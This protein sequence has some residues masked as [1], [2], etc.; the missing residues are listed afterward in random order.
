MPDGDLPSRTCGDLLRRFRE[1]ARARPDELQHR[2]PTSRRRAGVLQEELAGRTGLSDRGI[3]KIE[4]GESVPDP[5]TIA[6]LADALGLSPEQRALFQATANR[7]RAERRVQQNTRRL[8]PSPVTGSAF[9]VTGSASRLPLPPLIGRTRE[10][11]A[12]DHHI[13]GDGPPVLVF[14][15]E[16]GIGKSRLLD[17]AAAPCRTRRCWTR[18]SNTSM[19]NQWMTCGRNSAAA[20]GW[21]ACCLSSAP[22]VA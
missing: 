16:P 17:E 7:E 1:Q 10:L 3:R 20:P 2:S 15:G 18:S 22:P 12:L 5:A 6:V 11:D 13:V 9:L 14:A 8:A 21:R 4:G 19:G